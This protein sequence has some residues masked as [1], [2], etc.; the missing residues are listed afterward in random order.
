[1]ANYIEN[2]RIA[3]LSLGCKVNAYETASMRNQ[4]EGLGSRT[5]GFREIADVYLVN[6]CTV[7]NI[8]DRKSRQMLHQAKKRNPAAVVVAVGCYVQEFYKNH[9]T[10]ET[11]DLLIGNRRKHEVA[12]ILQ[13]YF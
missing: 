7:T 1:M 5:V 11:I 12:E 8:A 2:L 10:D 6:T 4:L 13:A 3:Y 9:E